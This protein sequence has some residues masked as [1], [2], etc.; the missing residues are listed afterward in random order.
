MRD[1]KAEVLD[2]TFLCREHLVASTRSFWAGRMFTG[3]AGSE[4]LISASSS[5]DFSGVASY[6]AGFRD[7]LL[8]F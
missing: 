7:T 2:P 5:E 8:Q 3:C 1:T 4:L 6:P